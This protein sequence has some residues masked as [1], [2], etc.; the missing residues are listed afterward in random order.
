MLILTDYQTIICVH[1][2][3]YI[4]NVSMGFVCF[5]KFLE[6]IFLYVALAVLES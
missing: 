2:S 3:S 1:F 6:T 5:L 4:H